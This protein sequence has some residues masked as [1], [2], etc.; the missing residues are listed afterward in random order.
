LAYY[1]TTHVEVAGISIYT[2]ASIVIGP[3]VIALFPAVI[4]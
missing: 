2:P 3:A 1:T 4:V